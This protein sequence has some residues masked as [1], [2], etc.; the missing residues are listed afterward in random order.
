F[1][2]P[3]VVAYLTQGSVNNVTFEPLL[4]MGSN[5]FTVNAST[6]SYV[7]ISMD[8]VLHGAA[9]VGSSGTVNVPL[10]AFTQTGNA[11]II[12]TKPQYQPVIT[13]V[14]VAP[15]AGPY[16]AIDS[17]SISSGDDDIIEYGEIVYLTVTLKNI[18]TETAT[19]VNMN[20]S[21]SDAF[22]TLNDNSESFG[23]IAVGASVTRTNAFRWTM[24]NTVPNNHVFTI[25]TNIS[26]VQ[27]SWTPSMNFTAYRP[28]INI[29]Q[30]AVNDGENNQLDPGETADITVTLS[31]SG[32]AK[33]NNVAGL[34][35]TT[36]QY[37]TINSNSSSIG[38]IA[39]GS[40]GIAQFNVTVSGNTPIGQN[41]SFGLAITAHNSY[42]NNNTF[43]QTVGL[44]LEDFESGD[45]SSYPW[46]FSG[47]GNWTISNSLPHE[48]TY[49]AKSGTIVHSQTT[50]LIL[51]AEVSAAGN[52]S[53]YKKVSSESNYD[54]L[55]FYIDDVQQGQWSGTV[56][57]SQETYTVEAGNRTFRWSY[58]KD[59]SL[60]SNDDCAWIDYIVFPAFEVPSPSF[61]VTPETLNFGSVFVEQSSQQ[62]I[63]ITNSGGAALS[64]SIT[65]PLGYTVQTRSERERREN[66]SRETFRN[67]QEISKSEELDRNTINYTISTDSSQEF[68]IVFSPPNAATY[69]GNIVISSN[70]ANNL[71]T[72]VSVSGSG[73][74][75]PQV[76][77]SPQSIS[78]NLSTDATGTEILTISNTGGANLTYEAGFVY[79]S[80]NRTT[81][82]E[83]NFDAST[84][85]PT[86]WQ[87]VDNQGNGQVWQIGT[88][89]NGLIIV[90]G[91]YIYLNSD[92]FGSG[93][94]QNSDLISP[95]VDLTNYNNVTLSFT[96]Y[97]NQYQEASSAT[98]LYSIND[99]IDWTQIQQ[100]TEDTA[101]PDD[102][103]QL[104]P[105]LTGQDNVRFKWN[106]TGSYAW[107]WDIDD[108]LL[109]AEPIGPVYN[110]LS[111]DGQSTSVGNVAA[112]RN[113]QISVQFDTEGLESG[114]YQAQ[115][116]LTTN[117][118][119]ST[120]IVIPVS[121][122]I[123]GISSPTNV[124]I[125][126]IGGRAVISWE[127]VSGATSYL[128]YSSDESTSNFVIDNSGTF[129]GTSWTSA[130]I[131]GEVK[132]FY[133][134]KA[135]R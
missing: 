103:S 57:W 32:G 50:S 86:G 9:L 55:R 56:A 93:E 14:T 24:S 100:W 47:N 59:G 96:H 18:G 36:S 118:P 58:S 35:T 60:S 98:L 67:E 78:K 90:S 20:I 6:G 117:D 43:N 22:V 126:F 130:P 27:D 19:S 28:D 49:S 88:H 48:G 2:D 8:G 131:N 75:P 7:A 23:N 54:F 70:D 3:S 15:L 134:V 101:N 31:N 12:V 66:I 82:L 42:T 109:T 89:S 53:F 85:L 51:T 121:L 25:N 124:S 17:Y 135:V 97:F 111:L 116:N 106:F 80:R 84:D 107:F 71:T 87:I 11:D 62:S 34:L 127:A 129:N 10:T 74:N 16:V 128:I 77:I 81:L 125:E 91:N 102:F 68:T 104:L 26:C 76:A 72:N 123:E 73:V 69:N 119:R 40:S 94:S 114:M 83:E 41:V 5:E 65:T 115:I 64:G 46:T 52:I 37:V 112:G 4:P 79:V 95:I 61:S 30:V 39:A 1:G 120:S 44:N 29:S 110:W 21:E 38:V 132:K 122:I 63:T 99:G 108:V 133:F 33:A 92:G 113:A 105:E 45:F 13:T